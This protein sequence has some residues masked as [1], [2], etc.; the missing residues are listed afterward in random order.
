MSNMQV[1]ISEH[2]LSAEAEP[3]LRAGVPFTMAMNLA[4][5]SVLERA[6]IKYRT[7]SAFGLEPPI[8]EPPY[9][10]WRDPL[11]MDLVIWQCVP[12]W[13]APT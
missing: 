11:T 4:Y 5:G 13:P 12:K 9:E 7:V 1:R 2:E 6:G 3:L 8:L 10:V